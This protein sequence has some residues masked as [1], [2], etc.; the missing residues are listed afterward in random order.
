IYVVREPDVGGDRLLDRLAGSALRT[1]IRVIQLNGFKDPSALHVDDPRHFREEWDRA[2]AAAVPLI[3]ELAAER[4]R[5]RD[6]LA[7]AAAA[8]THE[9]DILSRFAADLERAGVVGEARTAKLL[10][11]AVTSRLLDRLVSVAVKGTSSGGK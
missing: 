9:R 4:Q 8:L 10:Y 11:L 5:R 3:V 6:E 1:R 7:R 2:K